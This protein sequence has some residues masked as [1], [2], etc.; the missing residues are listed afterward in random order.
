MIH[1][2]SSEAG[3][4]TAFEASRGGIMPGIHDVYMSNKSGFSLLAHYP[5]PLSGAIPGVC[6]SRT[7]RRW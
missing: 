4:N 5:V 3:N 2:D 1:L 6:Q 7:V